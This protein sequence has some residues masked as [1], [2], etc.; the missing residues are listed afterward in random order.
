MYQREVRHFVEEEGAV[1]ETRHENSRGL[2]E[3]GG[4]D[5]GLVFGQLSIEMPRRLGVGDL[6]APLL[7]GHLLGWS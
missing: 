1:R 4:R 6:V 2:V 5:D 3:A 7:L